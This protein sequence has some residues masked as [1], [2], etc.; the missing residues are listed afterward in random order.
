MKN[1][2]IRVLIS[3]EKEGDFKSLSQKSIDR[4]MM[5]FGG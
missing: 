4:I 1:D 2:K 5:Q 3:D